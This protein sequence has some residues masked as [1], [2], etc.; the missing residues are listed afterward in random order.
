MSSRQTRRPTLPTALAG[1]L[2][3]L[4]ALSPVAIA[5]TASAASKPTLSRTSTAPQVE[6][7]KTIT[8]TGT[9]PRT[10][11]GDRVVFQRKVGTEKW[12][13]VKRVKVTSKGT[14]STTSSTRGAG[15]NHF[16]VYGV[17]KIVKK[18]KKKVEKRSY[19]KSLS[20]TSLGWFHLYD[21]KPTRSGFNR[22][23]ADLNGKKYNKSLGS[24]SGRSNGW[25]QVNLHGYCDTFRATIGQD[26]QSDSGTQSRF[27]STVDGQSI[28]HGVRGRGQAL[29]VTRKID[30]AQTLR[31]SATRVTSKKTYWGMWGNA[32]VRCWAKP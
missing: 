11:V 16:R 7:G 13:T 22:Y 2:A 10:F 17:T 26:D 32:R 21:L 25:G 15:I 20:V 23:V 29:G 6:E 14:F 27:S 24:R 18:G 5:P 31:V 28:D 30:G 9:A 12:A 8:F 4:L 19:A 1:G 3:A